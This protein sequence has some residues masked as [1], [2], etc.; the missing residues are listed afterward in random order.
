MAID[1]N[2]EIR[3]SFFRR[4]MT[5]GTMRDILSELENEDL[6]MPNRVGNL[7]IVRDRTRAVIGFIDFSG[8]KLDLLEGENG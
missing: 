7:S 5:V 4:W 3:A 1:I 6:L 8:E 2:V